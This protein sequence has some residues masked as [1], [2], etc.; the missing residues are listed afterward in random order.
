M[1]SVLVKSCGE[2]DWRQHLGGSMGGFRFHQ[3]QVVGRALPT[4]SDE[5]PKIYRMKLWATNEVRAKSK[6]WYFLRK[7]KKVKKSNGQVLA[8]NEV[9]LIVTL[10]YPTANVRDKVT[11]AIFIVAESRLSELPSKKTKTDRLVNSM[12]KLSVANTE[13]KGFMADKTQHKKDSGSYE[14]L[15]K[16]SGSSLVG[17]KYKPVFDYFLEFSE[18]A[19]SVV[20][21]NY[22][23]DDSGTG[24]VHCAPAFG[25]DDYRVCIAAGVIQK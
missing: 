17:I 20:A 6:F 25:E 15:E 12:Q 11:G 8:I 16:L 4:P 5:H 18:V 3:Y 22:V 14:L 9:R 1:C 21:D 23:T 19:F 13:S 7:L 10:K 2:V 24:V